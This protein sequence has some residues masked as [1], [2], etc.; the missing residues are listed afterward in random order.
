MNDT[1][2]ESSR[3]EAPRPS[4]AEI[5]RLLA[6]ELSLASRLGYTALLLVSIAG[7]GITGALLLTEPGLP[8][9]TQIALAILVGIAVSWAV[10][11]TWVLTRR[12]V[13]LAGPR[14]VASRMAVVFTTVFT[15]GAWALGQWGGTGRTWYSA[16]AVGLAMLAVAAV[17]LVQA[18]RRFDDLSRRRVALERQLGS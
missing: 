6:T 18:R 15:L 16:V 2:R 3:A 14:V 8:A 10:F 5:R 1:I 13:L 4:A 11:A 17:L 7:A 9:R 12:R